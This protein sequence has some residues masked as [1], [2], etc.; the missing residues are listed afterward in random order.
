MKN[1][2][3]V[4]L[5][6]CGLVATAAVVYA[7][8]KKG[9]Y[10]PAQLGAIQQAAPLPASPDASYAVDAYP[11]PDADLAPGDGLQ[12]VRIYSAPATVRATSPCSRR[13]PA[14]PGKPR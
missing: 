10:A 4:F 13:F 6:V 14:P 12:D 8:L 11:V 3:A 7:D 9:D 2:R 5:L 1:T